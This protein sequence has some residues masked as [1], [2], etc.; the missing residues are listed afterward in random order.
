MLSVCVCVCTFV[1]N[2]PSV[3]FLANDFDFWT[4]GSIII[5][6][7]SSFAWLQKFHWIRFVFGTGPVNGNDFIGITI[8]SVAC[9]SPICTSSLSQSSSLISPFNNFKI[10][11]F[12]F[13]FSDDTRDVY[14]GLLY[15]FIHPET[16]ATEINSKINNIHTNSSNNNNDD[17]DVNNKKR[18]AFPFCVCV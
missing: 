8:C 5:Q 4:F 11:L 15:D 18:A 10:C 13:I 17:H 12:D 7:K 1:V 14:E 2:Y 6:L 3:S 16:P 9:Y